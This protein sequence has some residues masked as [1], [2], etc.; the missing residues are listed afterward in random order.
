MK[1]K[2][3]GNKPI[4]QMIDMFGLE[5]VGNIYDDLDLLKCTTYN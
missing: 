3:I 2:N 5:Y 1:T 4:G